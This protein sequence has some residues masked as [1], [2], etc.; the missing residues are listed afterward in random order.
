MPRSKPS[1]RYLP[2]ARR[3]I[4]GEPQASRRSISR[5][6]AKLAAVRRARRHR[7]RRL[8]GRSSKKVGTPSAARRRK[9]WGPRQ[10]SETQDKDALPP[11]KRSTPVPNI[12]P[13]F[14][15]KVTAA[16]QALAPLCFPRSN[17]HSLAKLTAI[18]GH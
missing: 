6:L 5:S 10:A 15:I 7:R 2:K 18:P 1:L 17:S 11:Q 3:L 4:A 9:A 12:P 13:H 16:G 8:T 14:E